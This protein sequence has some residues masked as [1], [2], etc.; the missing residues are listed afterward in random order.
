MPAATVKI[1]KDDEVL[2]GSETGDGPVDA[3]FKAIEN[4][5]GYVGELE[6]YTIQ[7]VGHGQDAQGHVKISVNF[8]GISV[9]GKGS[10]TDVIKA[11][12]LAYLNAINHYL[13]QENTGK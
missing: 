2:V 9:I 11:S 5:T 4:C 3:L 6:E 1:T 8:G 10:S 12:A 13:V 7:A